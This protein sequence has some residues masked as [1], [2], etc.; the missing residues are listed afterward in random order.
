MPCS[1]SMP[2]AAIRASRA[3]RGRSPASSCAPRSNGCRSPVRCASARGRNHPPCRPVDGIRPQHVFAVGAAVAPVCAALR[4]QRVRA[5][6]NAALAETG[7]GAMAVDRRQSPPDL[8]G[9]RHEPKPLTSSSCCAG[10]TG[11]RPVRPFGRWI[12]SARLGQHV[13]LGFATQ[14]VAAYQPATDKWPRAR[15]HRQYRPAR[16]GRADAAA[17]YALGAGPHV[18]A[19]VCRRRLHETSDSTFIDFVNI[20]QHRMMALFY[21][22]WADAIRPCRSSGGSADGCIRCC[23]PWPGWACPIRMAAARG[24][25]IS[26]S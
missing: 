6:Q 1:T 15:H 26:S 23:A 20:L 14:D 21:R 24:R 3:M 19:L 25:S 2:I 4:H 16:A 7:G 5:N 12:R 11:R 18:A 13:R 22:A 17:S 10:S 8:T 9:G